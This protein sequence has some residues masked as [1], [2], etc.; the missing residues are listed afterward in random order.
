[1]RPELSDCI[2]LKLTMLSYL[3]DGGHY[4]GPAAEPYTHPSLM[5]R[6]AFYY[7]RRLKFSASPCKGNSPGY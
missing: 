5:V 4:N 7:E 6:A 1:M 3:D 2:Y